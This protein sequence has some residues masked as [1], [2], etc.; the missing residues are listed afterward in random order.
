[1][2]LQ[3]KAFLQVLVAILSGALWVPYLGSFPITLLLATVAT[4][5]LSLI[6]TK[7]GPVRYVHIFSKVTYFR[8]FFG[9]PTAKGS[10]LPGKICKGFLPCIILGISALTIWLSVF[11][12]V[13][14]G[15]CKSYPNAYPCSYPVF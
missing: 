8:Y 9:L 10:Y 5:I 1:M 11:L 15:Y 2:F 7:I 3:S 4:F 13:T 14:F 12:F 6:I